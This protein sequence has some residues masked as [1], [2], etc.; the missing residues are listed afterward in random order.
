MNFKIKKEKFVNYFF[1]VWTLLLY[2]FLVFKA[3]L[4]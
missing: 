1:L 3:Q 2:V 4:A